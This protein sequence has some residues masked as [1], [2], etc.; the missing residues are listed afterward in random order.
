MNTII[1]K[2]KSICLLSILIFT[3]GGC[4][5]ELDVAPILSYDGQANTT[6]AELIAM[7]NMGD[8][9]SSTPITDDI[10]IEGTIISSDQQGNCYKYITI[11]DATGGIQIKIDDSKLYPK[12]KIGQHVFVECKGLD[13]GDYRKNPQLGWWVDGSMSGIASK[14]EDMFIH[15]DGAVG[16]EPAPIVINSAY[17]IPYDGSYCNRLVILKNCYFENRGV[18]P[19]SATN[20]STSENIIFSDGSKIVMRTSNY[21][22]FASEILPNGTGDITGILTVYTTYQTTYQLTIRSTAD[23]R[24]SHEETI[25]EVDFNNN[26]LE[27]GWQV[28]NRTGETGWTYRNFQGQKM[29]TIDNEDEAT[30]SWLVS[31]AF[32]QFSNYDNLLFYFDH[33][34]NNDYSTGNLNFYYSTTY[35]GGQIIPDD[36][37]RVQISHFSTSRMTTFLSIPRE[38]YTNP[39]FRLAFQYAET[40]NSWVLYSMKFNANVPQ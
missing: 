19:Y 33:K 25:H 30:D 15:R 4:D 28:V 20:S 26:P 6:I 36:W 38:A 22:K 29:L 13:L 14:K 1:N 5:K 16:A 35:T 37:T 40:N 23:V 32:N 27:N 12:Y 39:N 17:D 11:Q 8:S 2:I 18:N 31:P 10:V 3:M 21:A 34:V 7:H 9:D 24:M